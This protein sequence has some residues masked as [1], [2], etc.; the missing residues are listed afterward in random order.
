MPGRRYQSTNG[1]W[2]I[3]YVDD[4]RFVF[5]R[6]DVAWLAFEITLAMTLQVGL[7]AIQAFQVPGLRWGLAITLLGCVATFLP[8]IFVSWDAVEAALSV[9]M[10]VP[11]RLV[12][13]RSN[14]GRADCFEAEI[15]RR[16]IAPTA[17]RGLVLGELYG[18]QRLLLLLG[19]EVIEVWR[20][21]RRAGGYI[22][23]EF[24]WTMEPL[25]GAEGSAAASPPESGKDVLLPLVEGLRTVLE[26]GADQPRSVQGP[27]V[28]VAHA[29][30]F[31][32]LVGGLSLVGG[33]VGTRLHEAAPAIQPWPLCVAIGLGAG[34]SFVGVE[35]LAFRTLVR[36]HVRR[37][38]DEILEAIQSNPMFWTR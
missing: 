17:K 12:V 33:L 21:I 13:K 3:P 19:D 25:E 24:D 7:I 9:R 15:D 16:A 22:P 6:R 14:Q 1:V 35:F 5:A 27:K 38:L 36:W 20:S 2:V 8:L 11:R 29:L 26:L 28:P 31:L 18:R 32:A 30:L 10:R 4:S 23:R 37:F 34:L